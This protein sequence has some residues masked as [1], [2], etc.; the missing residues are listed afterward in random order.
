MC[1]KSYQ[2]GSSPGCSCHSDFGKDVHDMKRHEM[3]LLVCLLAVH[4]LFDGKGPGREKSDTFLAL[5][6]RVVQ[7]L[8]GSEACDVLRLYA[9]LH[10]LQHNQELVLWAVAV[11]LHAE[12]QTG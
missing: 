2:T 3:L 6:D 5:S 9:V 7:P 8:P 11:K 10:T 12:V 1:K 4:G